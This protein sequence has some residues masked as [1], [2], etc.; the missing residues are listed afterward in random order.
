MDIQWGWSTK[1]IQNLNGRGL[2]CFPMVFGFPVVD[3]KGVILFCFPMFR[4]IGPNFIS[5]CLCSISFMSG[6]KTIQPYWKPDMMKW[7]MNQSI[8][9]H[10]HELIQRWMAIIRSW[11]IN[12][13]GNFLSATGIW[14][15]G[16][17]IWVC[18][19]LCFHS[20]L[21]WPLINN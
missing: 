4:T 12:K 7:L 3:K 19:K 18:S 1:H 9:M 17:W 15:T 11:L 6:Y 10:N 13:T 21:K 8:T 16:P 20:M 14:N 2:F 5:K